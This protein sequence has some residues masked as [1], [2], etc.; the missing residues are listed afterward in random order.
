MISYM[1]SYHWLHLTV[2]SPEAVAFHIEGIAA[3]LG[4]ST[5]ELTLPLN[6][7]KCPELPFAIVAGNQV[8]L[9]DGIQ[10]PC[11]PLQ[12]AL[13]GYLKLL[14]KVLAD[15]RCQFCR[16]PAD[17]R[18]GFAIRILEPRWARRL[19]IVC[20]HDIWLTWKDIQAGWLEKMHI[21]ALLASKMFVGSAV[22]R[23]SIGFSS[24]HLYIIY[25]INND[26]IR[27]L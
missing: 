24:L 9:Q 2:L 3:C 14:P 5:V 21:Q 16:K 6:A 4:P 8:V 22:S 7:A 1:I 20:T 23:S 12:V 17:N 10:L 18:M 25:D 26:I 15:P 27:N 19:Q 13:G 11:S